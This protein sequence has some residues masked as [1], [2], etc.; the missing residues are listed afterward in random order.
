MNPLFLLVG[1]LFLLISLM[2]LSFVGILWNLK[3]LYA[4]ASQ[5]DAIISFLY[6][7]SA[8]QWLE[9]NQWS[10]AQASIGLAEDMEESEPSP[11]RKFTLHRQ[12]EVY[13]TREPHLAGMK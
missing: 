7:L 2:F 13:D 9:A 11:E 8:N 6:N 1:G 10:E 5:Q 3:Q 4:I 12:E